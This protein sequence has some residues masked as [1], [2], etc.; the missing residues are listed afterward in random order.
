[1][2]VGVFIYLCLHSFACVQ[3]TKFKIWMSFNSSHLCTHWNFQETWHGRMLKWKYVASPHFFT[4][5][6]A[7]VCS[8]CVYSLEKLERF[9]YLGCFLKIKQVTS[10]L[11]WLWVCFNINV[12]QI[13]VERICFALD[14]NLL[15]TSDPVLWALLSWSMT[16]SA[17]N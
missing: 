5:C 7:V 10:I 9:C 1:M 12:V 16:C 6:I 8:V 17:Q 15:F 11:F 3:E 2:C 13:S 4:H 14:G